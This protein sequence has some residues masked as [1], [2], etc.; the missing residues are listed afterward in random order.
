MYIGGQ[1][2]SNP[3]GA[4]DFGGGM[5][6]ASV[7][8]S[9]NEVDHGLGFS[10]FGARRIYTLTALMLYAKLGI[11]LDIPF[12]EDDD[13]QS[14]TSVIL[15]WSLGISCNLMLTKKSDIE[16]NFGYRLSAKSSDWSYSEEEERYDAFWFEEMP[17][18]D[19]SGFYF[20]VGYKFILF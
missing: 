2:H 1:F 11:N 4:W 5:H 9:Y 12:K 8:D 10:V 18:V 13:G 14:V 15:S 17:V 3:L 16:I 7:T 19:L 20:T 6:Y